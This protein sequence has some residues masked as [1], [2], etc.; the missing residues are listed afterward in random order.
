VEP[1]ED[2]VLELLRHR[3]HDEP[4]GERGLIDELR[5]DRRDL[6][7]VVEDRDRVVAE[8]RRAGDGLRLGERRRVMHQPLALLTT[9]RARRDV[10]RGRRIRQVVAA[11]ALEDRHGGGLS[12]GT[13]ACG[14]ER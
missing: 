10:R 14:G 7:E 1:L 2:H 9:L 3:R 11:R 4:A 6:L 12:S 8:R 13:A 5:R